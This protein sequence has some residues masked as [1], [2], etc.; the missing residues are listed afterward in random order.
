[1]NNFYTQILKDF[2]DSCERDSKHAEQRIR[3]AKIRNMVLQTFV[4]AAVSIFSTIIVNK[5]DGSKN[6]S[7]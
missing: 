6:T 1:M 7:Q 2:N 4:P 3:N 5:L